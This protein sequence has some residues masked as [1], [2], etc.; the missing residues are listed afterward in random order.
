M[1][2]AALL[3]ILTNNAPLTVAVSTRIYLEILPERTTLPA[4]VYRV[5]ITEHEDCQDGRSLLATSRVEIEVFGNTGLD[6]RNTAELVRQA[7]HGFTGTVGDRKIHAV[8]DWSSS[9]LFEDDTDIWDA[10]CQC[11]IWHDVPA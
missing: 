7:L 8:I 6:A 10:T 1:I 9:E 5:L 3:D 2:E 11:S 4:V